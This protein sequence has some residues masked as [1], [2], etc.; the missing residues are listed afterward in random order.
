M[1]RKFVGYGA[2]NSLSVDASSSSSLYLSFLSLTYS[3]FSSSLSSHVIQDNPGPDKAAL[4]VQFSSPSS[5]PIP[6]L[7]ISPRLER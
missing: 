3:P 2:V 4:V 1:H 7:H 6:F 5:K